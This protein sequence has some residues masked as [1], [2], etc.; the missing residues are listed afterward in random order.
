MND[1]LRWTTTIGAALVSLGLVTQAAADTVTLRTV[2]SFNPGTAIPHTFEKFLEEIK[3][4]ADAPVQINFIGGPEAMP[5]FQVGNAVSNGVVDMAFVTSAFYTS[6][7]PAA[8]ALNLTRFSPEELRETGRFEQ[9]Q[10][11]WREQMNVHY[12]AYTNYGNRYHLYLNE[13]IDGP[14][15]NGLRMRI[16][17]VYRA[18]VEAM[19][20]EA[21]Q[22]PP[23]EVYTAL[24]RGIVD[25][26]GWPIQ[27]IFDLGW[28]E[29]TRYRVDPG[30]YHVEVGVLVNQNTWDNLTDEQRDY[31]TEKAIWLEELNGLNDEIN[32]EEERRQAEAGIEVIEFEGEDRERFLEMAYEAQWER[33][34]QE[35]AENTERLREILDSE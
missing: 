21:A 33:L 5:P 11:M 20:G 23:G 30:F 27:G 13:P 17:P 9:L 6:S 19:G 26:Y 12:L 2:S 24:E 3:N 1:K 35:H 10:E 15:L 16:T 25:G 8:H 7:L 22:T 14:E 34:A 28:N 4:D 29:H 32:A 31:L 18:F